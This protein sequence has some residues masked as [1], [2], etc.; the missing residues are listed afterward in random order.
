MAQQLVLKKIAKLD[1]AREVL[2][3]LEA[4][5]CNIFYYI[6]I[7]F[8]SFRI[9]LFNFIFNYCPI[10]FKLI[11]RNS[12][13]YLECED[14]QWPRRVTGSQAVSSTSMFSLFYFILF[15]LNFVL[16]CFVL[17]C[18]VLFCF[19]L[20]CFV[21]F[22]FVLFCFVLFCFVLVIYYLADFLLLFVC[23]TG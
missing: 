8:L 20:F 22:C 4:T 10:V 12:W 7:I 15:Y 18:F 9:Y 23:I 16:F 1:R 2:S 21:L 5:V 17:F 14:I 19:V 6:L 3:A 13:F 11:S